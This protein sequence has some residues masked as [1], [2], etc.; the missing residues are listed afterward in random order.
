MSWYYQDTLCIGMSEG[1]DVWCLLFLQA[2]C[3]GYLDLKSSFKRGIGTV[4]PLP[5]FSCQM[6]AH[7]KTT[8]DSDVQMTPLAGQKLLSCLLWIG[9]ANWEP[10]CCCPSLD[11]LCCHCGSSGWTQKNFSGSFPFF[12][13]VE[14]VYAAFQYLPSPRPLVFDEHDLFWDPWM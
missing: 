11:H 14:M 6:Q 9:L 4:L 3:L 2:A 1:V 7:L 8:A 13:L 10:V 12:F 5:Y